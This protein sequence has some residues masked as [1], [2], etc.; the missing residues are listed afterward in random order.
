MSTKAVILT[1]LLSSVV[2]A[3]LQMQTTGFN[4]ENLIIEDLA[5][6]VRPVGL[7]TLLVAVLYLLS[8]L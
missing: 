1:L 2:F 8:V 5:G 3:A 4:L 7:V 6:N